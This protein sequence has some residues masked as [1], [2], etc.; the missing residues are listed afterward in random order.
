MRAGEAQPR[1]GSSAAPDQP[2]AG[3]RSS[4]ATEAGPSSGPSRQHAPR[5]PAGCRARRTAHR[6]GARTRPGTG[7]CRSPRRNSAGQPPGMPQRAAPERQP[8]AAPRRAADPPA[9][10]RRAARG[11]GRRGPS[12]SAQACAASPGKITPQGRS[13]GRPQ[14]SALMKFAIRPSSS[15]GGVPSAHRSVVEPNGTRLARRPEERSRQDAQ[16]AAVERHAALPQ[17]RDLPRVAQ[18]VARLVEQ[19]VA[20][21]PAGDD[22]DD[23][24][25]HQRLERLGRHRRRLI[26]PE[27]R[28]AQRGDGD[29]PA[30]Q[31][32]RDIGQRVPAQRE[33]PCRGR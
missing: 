17:E 5:A 13:V 24:P 15:P 10:S 8:A 28:P 2:E 11:G 33:R 30:D 3:Q 27:P 19:H 23:D 12:P 18:V 4:A 20:E 9:G 14:S 16:E 6:A 7:R 21:P 29:P 22:P 31:D 32:S 25:G 1:A 26:R